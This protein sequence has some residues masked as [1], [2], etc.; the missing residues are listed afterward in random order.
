M[1][2]K[3]GIVIDAKHEFP[4]IF[5]F[6][7]HFN[8]EFRELSNQW[9]GGVYY[10]LQTLVSAPANEF[11]GQMEQVRRRIGIVNQ[12]LRLVPNVRIPRVLDDGCKGCRFKTTCFNVNTE[13]TAGAN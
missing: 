5:V 3:Y 8:Q 2:V 4:Y 9:I 12:P 6:G 7:P 13:D 11:L 10:H 1:I